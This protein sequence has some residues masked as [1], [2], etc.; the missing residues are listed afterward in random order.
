MSLY[1]L[2]D[3]TI[4]IETK[5]STTNAWGEEIASF[6]SSSSAIARV[7]PISDEMRITLQGEYKDVTHKAYLQSSTSLS[8]DDRILYNGDEF[9]IRSIIT[10]SFNNHKTLLLERLP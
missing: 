4:Y 9:R 1:S 7:V 2:L 8:Y 3:D 6:T 10:D 5:T